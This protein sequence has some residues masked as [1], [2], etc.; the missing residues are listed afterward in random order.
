MVKENGKVERFRENG[1]VERFRENGKVERFRENGKVERF[2][3]CRD[4]I[5][6]LL[7]RKWKG[8]TCTCIPSSKLYIL[9][10]L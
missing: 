3:S 10:E 1:K 8:A 9:F 5:P 6:P 7:S 4:L 2:R